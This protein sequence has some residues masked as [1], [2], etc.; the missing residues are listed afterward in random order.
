[1]I[2]LAQHEDGCVVSVRAQPGARRSGILGTQQGALKV[3]VTAPAEAGKANQ[4]LLEVLREQL[5]LR[6]SELEL[7][8]GHSSRVKRL[9]IRGRTVAEVQALLA[10]LLG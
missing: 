1:M 3:A 9:L 4:A 10:T 8:S 7:I 6:R 5:G 2:T